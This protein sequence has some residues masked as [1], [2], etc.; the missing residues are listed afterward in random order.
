MAFAQFEMKL[1][2]VTVLSRWQL[3]LTNSKPM[4][5]VRRGLLLAPPNDF[6]MVAT[7]MRPQNQ[8]IL[9]TSSM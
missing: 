4:L 7:G 2:L 3:E 5:P 1:I 9:Q 6:R 8:R